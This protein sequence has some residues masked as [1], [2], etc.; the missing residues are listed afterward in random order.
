MR[1]V[2]N[3]PGSS[4]L[5]RTCRGPSSSAKFFVSKPSPGRR[6]LEIAIKGAASFAETAKHQRDGAPVGN[7]G[8]EL[9]DQPDGAE[10]H[11][12]ERRAPCLVRNR[13]RLAGRRAADA[14]EQA[15]E[16]A[17]AFHHGGFQATRQVGIGIVAGEIGDP[18]RAV[19]QRFAGAVEFLLGPAR[20]EDVRAL[21]DQRPHGRKAGAGGAAGDDE[22]FS[23]EAEIHLRRVLPSVS[24]A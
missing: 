24:R 5:I 15:I 22:C 18:V 20:D 12:L 14:D 10:E 4:A 11:A 1:S 8:R 3:M 16:P 9:A 21:R 19:R 2:A 23:V 6:P 13:E 17:A 7:D